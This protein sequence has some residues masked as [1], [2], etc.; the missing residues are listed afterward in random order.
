MRYTVP[1]FPEGTSFDKV[2]EVRVTGEKGTFQP[3]KMK[4]YATDKALHIQVVSYEKEMDKVRKG[5]TGKDVPIFHSDNI[6]MFVGVGDGMYRQLGVNFAG[7]TYDANG[8]DKSWN[9]GFAAKTRAEGD[10]WIAEMTLP[11]E[12]YPK[13]AKG[14]YW[15]MSIIRNVGGWRQEPCG[16]PA[17]IYRELNRMAKVYFE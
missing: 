17:A 15:R 9:S 4:L 11:F 13:P 2:P 8:Q 5:E 3:T 6:E 16:F 7:G 12:D 1:K 14:A 10:R